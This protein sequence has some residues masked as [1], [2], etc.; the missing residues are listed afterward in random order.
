MSETW[1]II[2]HTKNTQYPKSNSYF[3][4]EWRKGQKSS[5]KKGPTFPEYDGEKNLQI[6]GAQQTPSK[7]NKKKLTFKLTQSSH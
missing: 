2:K 5:L 6:K 7:I 1:T 4:G 3:E